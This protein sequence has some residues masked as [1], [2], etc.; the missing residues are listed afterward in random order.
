MG[1]LKSRKKIMISTKPLRNKKNYDRTL[2]N[3]FM[4][5]VKNILILDTNTSLQLYL[6]G[7]KI[8]A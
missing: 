3:G 5:K 7:S 2:W 8:C 4:C 1:Y 6:K